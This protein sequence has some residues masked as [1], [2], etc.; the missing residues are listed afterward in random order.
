MKIHHNIKILALMI[1]IVLTATGIDWMAH[2][3][4]PAYAVPPEYFR[5]KII[6]ASI[7]AIIGLF[8]L[9]NQNN[10]TKKAVWISLF[11][12]II[13][14]TKY[15]LQGYSLSFVLLFIPIHFIAFLLPMMAVFKTFPELFGSQ[16]SPEKAFSASRKDPFSRFR[17]P[18][19]SG[20]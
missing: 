6:Y 4:S 19:K 9:R 11:I 1:L 5:N 10:V 17:R 2:Q 12:A 3:I 15:F 18:G 16:P 8:T 20:Q 7:W 13:L 14:Q